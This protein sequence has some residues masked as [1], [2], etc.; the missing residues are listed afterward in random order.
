VTDQICNGITET[1]I[2]LIKSIITVSVGW[3]AVEC[4][5][6]V[7]GILHAIKLKYRNESWKVTQDFKE[8]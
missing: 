4:E 2:K 7:I 8:S 3:E 6:K 5:L 1:V